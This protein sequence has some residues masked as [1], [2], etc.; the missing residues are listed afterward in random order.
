[1][2]TIGVLTKLDL[3]TEVA[4]QKAIKDLVL[5]KGKQL[6]LGYCVVKNCSADDAQST[7]IKRLAQEVAFFSKP[8]WREIAAS[9][10]CGVGSLQIRLSDLLMNIT[11]REFP[12][13]KAEASTQLEQ[14]KKELEGMGPSR[15]DQSAQMMYLRRLGSKFQAVTQC[16]LN[17]YYDSELLFAETPSLK[18]ITAVTKANERFANAF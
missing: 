5:G 13:V 10:R 16:A 3:V 12:H 4:T 8:A 2:R 17:S 7:V 6:R 11:K 9:G 18:L 15:T 14:R 1:V